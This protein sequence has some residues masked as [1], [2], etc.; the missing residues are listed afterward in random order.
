[1]MIKKERVLNEIFSGKNTTYL[2]H[3]YHPYAA[4]FIPQIPRFF[5][6]EYTN[7]NEVVLDP[8]CGSGT[9]LVESL[10][11][12]RNAI[13]IDVHPI[14]TLISKVKTTPLNDH[15]LNFIL[16]WLRE[17][18]LNYEFNDATIT[19]YLSASEKIEKNSNEKNK[20]YYAELIDFP[21]KYHWFKKE[22]L[23]AIVYIK[24]KISEI[25]DHK[26]RDFLLTSLSSIIVKVSNQESET[27]YVAINKKYSERDVFKFFYDKVM[28]MIY[29]MREF[30]KKLSGNNWVKV[31]TADSRYIDFVKENSVDFIITSP[32]YPN[33][34][35]YYLYHKLRMYILGYRVN[36]V[37]MREIG[38]RNK[39]SSKREG[40]ENYIKDMI[41]CFNNFRRILKPN[42]FFV[43]VVGDS[44]IGGK[45]YDAFDI[46]SKIA[47]KSGFI[48]E[49]HLQYSL[50]K[51]SK[52]FNKSFRKRN[53]NE[54]III[55]KNE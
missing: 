49:D 40:I 16:K 11:L 2:T 30:S 33:V 47:G 54:H 29:R 50:D 7:E 32:P 41:L 17:L 39:H 48:V 19:R 1:M 51:V 55:L 46:I 35:D 3:N 34:Y 24:M 10:L 14:A 37:Q 53:K 52:L 13:G 22:I 44:I 9:A 42:R 25:M 6:K 20:F 27:R 36:D 31:Y 45:K 23:N 21:N 12:R 38:S 28:D 43:I 18:A 4:K 15:Q 8:F 5:I 26:I